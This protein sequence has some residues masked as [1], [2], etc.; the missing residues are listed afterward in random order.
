MARTP[1]I[2]PQRL[3]L[4]MPTWLGDCVMATPTLRAVRGL[5]PEAHIAVLI[6]DTLAPIVEALPAIDQVIAH[7][8]GRGTP[9][10][11]A[12]RGGPIRLVRRLAGMNFDLAVLLPNSFRAAALV[13]MAGIKRRVGYDRDGRGLL[14][15]DHLLPRKTA[16]R[17]TPVPTLDYYLALARYLGCDNPDPVMRLATRP[18]DDARAGRLLQDLGHGDDATRPLV[19][20]NPGAQKPTKRWPAERFAQLGDRLRERYDADIAITGSPAER[21]VLE[22][23]IG[24]SRGP[25]FNLPARG[26]DLHLLKAVTRRCDLMVTNDTGPRHIAAAFGVPVV[27]LFGPTGPEWTRIP[28]KDERMV[29]APGKLDPAGESNRRRPTRHM[30][31]I[32]VEQVFT[33]ADELLKRRVRPRA[34]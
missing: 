33:A 21:G 20:L 22:A 6:R 14:L 12:T 11:D 3:L 30:G 34:A 23:V 29:I 7:H 25:V 1:P 18:A 5:W 4:V 28:F 26:M 2:Q 8:K 27:T 9:A 19:L 15:T 13:A 16:G 24:A 32:E 10:P 17:F 31:L